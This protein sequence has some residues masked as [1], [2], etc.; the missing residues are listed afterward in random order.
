M[1]NFFEFQKIEEEKDDTNMNEE[2][3]DTIRVEYDNI[4]TYDKYV[5]KYAKYLMSFGI[6]NMEIP[7]SFSIVN[8]K[9][10]YLS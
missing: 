10:D 6:V 5:E 3:G 8:G 7:N 1:L 9:V 2:I 4:I